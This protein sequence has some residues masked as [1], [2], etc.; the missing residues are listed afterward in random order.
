MVLNQENKRCLNIGYT[1]ICRDYS[2]LEPVGEA[3]GVPKS[4]NP[5]KEVCNGFKLT[6][7]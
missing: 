7:K 3:R 2:Y 6:V 5:D 1:P 4:C